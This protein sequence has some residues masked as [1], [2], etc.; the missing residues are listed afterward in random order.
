M[1][2]LDGE[3]KKKLDRRFFKIIMLGLPLAGAMGASLLPL[4]QFGHQFLM[5]ILFIWLQAVILFECFFA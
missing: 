3:M 4:Q 5:L 1:V 2:F